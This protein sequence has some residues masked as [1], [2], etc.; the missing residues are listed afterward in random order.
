MSNRLDRA[1]DAAAAAS[2]ADD[3]MT[4]TH[5]AF[6]RARDAYFKRPTTY[7]HE[8]FVEARAAFLRAWGEP[9]FA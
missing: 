9:D 1:L 6:A 2:L 7:N 5:R 8:R 3:D 4:R